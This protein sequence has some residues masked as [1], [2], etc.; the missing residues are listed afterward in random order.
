LERAPGLRSG[1]SLHPPPED[2]ALLMLRRDTS[3]A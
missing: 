2:P 1:L 3:G